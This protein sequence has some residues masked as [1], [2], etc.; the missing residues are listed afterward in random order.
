MVD[1]LDAMTSE[2]L[3]IGTRQL[4]EVVDNK[5]P[6]I[7]NTL[8]SVSDRAWNVENV[9]SPLQDIEARGI[10]GAQSHSQF[11][12]HATPGRFICQVAKKNMST[13][14]KRIW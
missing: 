4:L 14:G 13:D 6:G 11:I 8:E 9:Q 3:K 10:D 5:M 1:D 7:R 2:S 12:I